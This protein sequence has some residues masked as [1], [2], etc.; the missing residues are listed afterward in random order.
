MMET[1]G[2]SRRPPVSGRR[3]FLQAGSLGFLGITTPQLFAF[4]QSELLTGKTAKAQ[5]CILL[6]LSGGPSHVD[7]WDPKPTSTFRPIRTKAAGVQVSE[8][9][10][11]T[12]QHMDKLAVIRSLKSEEVD[13]PEGTHYAITGHRPNPA[14]QFPSLGAILAKELGSKVEALPPHI[15]APS[16]TKQYED[17]WKAS[18]LGANYDPLVVPDPSQADFRLPDLTLPQA[19]SAQRIEDRRSFLRIVD[20][21]F[22][23]K[24]H[25]AEHAKLDTF[26]EQALKMILSP[27]VKKA[28]DLSAESEKVRDAY[29]RN[30][31]GQSALLARR[32]VEAGCRFVTAA[33]FKTGEWDTHKDS[34][35]GH[36]D[37]LVPILDQTLSTLLEDLKQR[38]MLES[39]IV[40]VMGEFGRT[41]TLNPA[42]GRDHW[43]FCWSLAVGGGGIQGGQVVGASDERGAYV[44]D[45]LVT[46]GDLYATVYKAFGIDW[47]K[48]YDTPIG[49][50]IKIAN[51][52]EDKTGNPIESLV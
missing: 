26:T 14:M 33:G 36:K 18:F 6:W 15:L 43:P 51:S 52:I 45:R 9:L 50:P 4:Q 49:R 31:C 27:A 30:R 12:A 21:E 44:A 47:T 38:G 48:T 10:P 17:Y 3:V 16:M 19:L 11:R 32:L 25:M 8:L 28:F 24:Q 40:L 42:S 5:S 34:D 35:K 13:H 20:E 2:N 41:P 23:Q 46:I 37:K 22:R 1:V 29:G 39:T 7:T